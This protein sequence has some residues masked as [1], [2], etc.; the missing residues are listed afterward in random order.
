MIVTTRVKTVVVVE[1]TISQW[2]INFLGIRQPRWRE[3]NQD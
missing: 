1:T 3:Y 2:S